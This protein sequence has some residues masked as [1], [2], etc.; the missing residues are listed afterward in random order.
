MNRRN[1]LSTTAGS[2]LFMDTGFRQCASARGAARSR[3]NLLLI[4]ADQFRPDCLGADGN[5][6]IQTPNLDRLA[7]RGIRFRHAYSATPTCTPARAALLTGLSPWNHGMLGYG[8]IAERYPIE[9]PRLLAQSGYYTAMI[10]KG[11]YSPQRNLHGFHFGLLDEASRVQ[12]IDFRNDYR[13]WFYSL[14]PNRDPDETGLGSNDY[15]SAPYGLPEQLHPTQWMGRTAVEFLSSYRR[16]EPFFLK[17]SFNRPHSPYDPPERWWKQYQDAD[18][19]KA[20]AGSWAKKYA[21]CDPT[22]YNLWHGDLGEKQVRKSRQGYYGSVSFVDEQIGRI[23]EALD[24]RGWTDQTLV[25]FTAD[26]GDM[27]GDHHLWRKSYAYEASAR[28]PLLLSWPEGMISAP[29]GQVSSQVVELR[30][31]LPTLLEAARAP[32]ALPMDGRSL[33]ALARG[34]QEDWRPWIDLEH[35]ICYSPEN[36]WNALTDGCWKYIFHAREGAEQLFHLDQDPR[37]REDLSGAT[38]HAET[39]RTWRERMIQHLAPR[40]EDFVKNGRLALRPASLP[41]SP[42]FPKTKKA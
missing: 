14:A 40:G 29:R 11:H 15:R 3:P 20:E 12:S 4:M 37:E 7:S 25:L 41:Y 26:H 28:I 32:A 6:V 31:V 19:P 23:L 34:P 39:L 9:M 8:E 18:L 10:G 27:T 1:F 13:S 38:A 30:D 35:D 5:G 22:D 36:H 42:N 24:Q 33:L 16:P 21:A 17:V 2:A